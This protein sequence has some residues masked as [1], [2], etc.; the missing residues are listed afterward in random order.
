VS[1]LIDALQV[2]DG[3]LAMEMDSALEALTGKTYYGDA[4]LWA[5]WWI[6]NKEKFLRELAEGKTPAALA[7]EEAKK[8]EA[9]KGAA[10]TSFYGIQTASKRIIFVLDH[11]GS[12]QEQ[13]DPKA[14]GAPSP[15]PQ[16]TGQGEGE[17]EKGREDSGDRFKPKDN[18]KVEIAKSELKK[19]IA[20]LPEDAS[21]TILFYNH[22]IEVYSATMIT[23]GKP[24]KE[25]AYSY[26]DGKVPAG[27]TNIHDALKAAFDIVMPDRGVPGGAGGGPSLTGEGAARKSNKG[28]AD[29]IFFLTDGKP[30]TGKILDPAGILAAVATWNETRRIQIHCVGIGDHDKDFLR[31]L[32][33]GN[34]GTYVGK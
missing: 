19:A 14:G 23:A 5:R 24:A 30:T 1:A 4:S 22:E 20:G 18:T 26:I 34:G 28:G 32:A 10:T 16:A 8:A 9:H 21:F 2:E 33:E 25:K 15:P 27:N 29:T 3:R 13:T 6:A 11:S 31:K 12:M 7:G 17:K